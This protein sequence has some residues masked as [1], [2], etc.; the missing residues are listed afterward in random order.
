MS[1]RR[2]TLEPDAM[3]AI[4]NCLCPECGGVIELET[5]RL[6]LWFSEIRPMSVL[7]QDQPV[8]DPAHSACEVLSRAA[9][10]PTDPTFAKQRG[11]Q[12]TRLRDRHVR[13][14]ET[15]IRRI[16]LWLGLNPTSYAVQAA[17]RSYR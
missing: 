2:N 14:G 10:I 7:P 15:R 5:D 16:A 12:F 4:V 13:A 9:V 8:S 6:E 3:S 11:C 1:V 17:R